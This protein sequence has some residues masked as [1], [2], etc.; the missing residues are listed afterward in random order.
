[1]TSWRWLSGWA[2]FVRVENSA[3]V[4]GAVGQPLPVPVTAGTWDFKQHLFPVLSVYQS[5]LIEGWSFLTLCLC[6]KCV[7][8]YAS[9]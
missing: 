2:G 1:M 3:G 5:L 7:G 8:T 6:T 9:N 4:G